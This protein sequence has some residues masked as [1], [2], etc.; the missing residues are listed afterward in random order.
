MM[1]PVTRGIPELRVPRR[2]VAVDLALA[3][4]PARR[5]ELAVEPRAGTAGWADVREVLEGDRAFLPLHEVGSDRWFL[6]NRDRIA[7]L[8]VQPDEAGDE[9]S[10]GAGSGPGEEEIL[11][12]QRVRVEIDLDGGVR[13]AGE[14]LFAAPSDQARTGDHLNGEGRFVILFQPDRVLLVSKAAVLELV[15]TSSET[16]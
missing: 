7:W 1:P 2:R 5:L 16:P 10:A 4:R 8:A 12:D 6:V 9:A 15:E 11:Y 14:L 13:L 3:G